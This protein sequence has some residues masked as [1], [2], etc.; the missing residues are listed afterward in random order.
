MI[1][2]QAVSQGCS[3][4]KVALGLKNVLPWLFMCLS[5][6]FSSSQAVGRRSISFLHSDSIYF[7]FTFLSFGARISKSI[8]HK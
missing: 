2:G 1:A 8:S 3:Y 4:V 5:A 6:G 7:T